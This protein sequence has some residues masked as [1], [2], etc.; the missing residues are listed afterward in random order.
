MRRKQEEHAAVQP[1][2]FTLVLSGVTEV[3]TEVE[4]ALFEAGCDDALVLSRDGVVYLD[5]DRERPSFREAVLSAITDVEQADIGAKVV[6]IEPDELVTMAEI[7]RRLK[8]SRE[9]IRQLASGLRG[10]GD[11]PPP[12]ANLTQRSPI[13]R[14]ADVQRWLREKK[15]LPGAR[16]TEPGAAPPM[17][18][19]DSLIAVLNA[20]LE[21][22][23]HLPSRTEA[24]RLMEA[25]L[26][27]ERRS[28][29]TGT[30]RRHTDKRQ[31]E[32]TN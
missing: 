8:R 6:R 9:S 17:A 26:V 31:D 20:V 2:K 21:V 1:W 5:F 16:A 30:A 23:R 29:K 15:L 27:P 19:F 3:T 13:Y 22:Q 12:V 14:W 25:L 4:G 11:F 7:A 24:I 28:R 10:P 18:S 32:A